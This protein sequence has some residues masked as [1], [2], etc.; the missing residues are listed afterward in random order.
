MEKL[1]ECYAEF[2]SSWLITPLASY[3]WAVPL[4]IIFKDEQRLAKTEALKSQ[5]KKYKE[6]RLNSLYIEAATYLENDSIEDCRKRINAILQI[7]PKHQFALR[8]KNR[9]T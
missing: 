2:Q 4:A 1:K 7:E 3:N 6:D 8:L 9:L 5:F